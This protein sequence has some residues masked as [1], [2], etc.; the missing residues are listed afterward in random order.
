MIG[1]GLCPIFFAT[2]LA[3]IPEF[4][5]CSISENAENSPRPA[6]GSNSHQSQSQGSIRTLRE[7]SRPP[8]EHSSTSILFLLMLKIGFGFI[9]FAVVL[10]S[11]VLSKLTLVSL[12]D[13]LRYHT[14]MY[15]NKSIDPMEED[16][17]KWVSEHR[18]ATISLY[19]HLLLILLV[20]NCVAFLRCLFFGALGKTRQ[21]YP[22]PRVRATLLVS[23]NCTTY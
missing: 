19:W 15:Q 23:I 18:D 20:P 8:E 11:S 10:V 3:G 14:W 2:L 21:S 4:N 7:N 9:L 22:W 16:E 12:T 1:S 17:T 6:A 13:S 5:V